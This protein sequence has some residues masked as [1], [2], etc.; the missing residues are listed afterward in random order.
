MSNPI[1]IEWQALMTFS[2]DAELVAQADIQAIGEH[3]QA[4]RD[5]LVIGEHDPLPLLARLDGDG[6][7]ADALDGSGDFVA[8]RVDQG[9]V[10]DVELPARC[11]VEQAAEAG[12]P[13]LAGKGRA[14]QH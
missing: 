7:G 9:I 12:D 2:G 1:E 8:D 4:G 10:E 3:H 11:L 13:V 14:A 6:L 5:R